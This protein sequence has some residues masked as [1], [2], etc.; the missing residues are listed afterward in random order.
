MLRDGRGNAQVYVL[1]DDNTVDLRLVELGATIEDRWL[2]Q[3]G[4]EPG[5]TVVVEGAQKLYPGATVVP[6]PVASAPADTAAAAGPAAADGA[7]QPPADA[8][9]DQAALPAAETTDDAPAPAE[10]DRAA[11]N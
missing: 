1:K 4:L 9:P 2:V 6:E 8:S 3:S 7:A 10:P 11:G 5:E